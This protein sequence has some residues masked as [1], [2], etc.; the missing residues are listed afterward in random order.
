MLGSEVWVANQSVYLCLRTALCLL[1]IRLN[2][3]PRCFSVKAVT[4]LRYSW[5]V[6]LCERDMGGMLLTPVEACEGKPPPFR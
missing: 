5:F 1:V 4:T 6:D 2:M 3:R